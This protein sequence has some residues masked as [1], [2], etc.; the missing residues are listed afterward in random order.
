MSIKCFQRAA[1]FSVPL[2]F[3]RLHRNHISRCNANGEVLQ[4]QR[5]QHRD[6]FERISQI[7]SFDRAYRIMD[8]QLGQ[9]AGKPPPRVEWSCWFGTLPPTA[10]SAR[11]V[12]RRVYCARN[13]TF[14]MRRLNVKSGT[15]PW[16]ISD[17]SG[18]AWLDQ[19]PWFLAVK[20]RM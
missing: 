16:K 18:C 2:D 7:Q 17:P 20:Q 6:D 9:A 1:I 10:Y 3:L 14:W 19:K 4:F 13:G 11:P 8:N 12:K 15:L 5:K